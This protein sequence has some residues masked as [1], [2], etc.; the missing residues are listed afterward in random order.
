MSKARDLANAGTALGAVS[1]TELAF[2]DGVTSAIQTQIDAKAPSSTAVTLTGTQ[3]L[4]NKTLTNPV[5]S[6]V[7]NNTL[8][9]TT[10]DMIY[11]SAANTP[12][13]LAIGSTDQVLKV[14]GGI[15]AW[16]TPSSGDKPVLQPSQS[17]FY[18]KPYT[19]SALV[20]YAVVKDRTYY[21][22]IY[23]SGYALDRIG[24]RTA[25]G[26]SGTASTR[27]GIYNVD[28]SGKPSTVFLDAGTVSS[29]AASTNFEITI[30]STPPAGY[31]YLA[32]NMQT[33]GAS[34]E[35]AAMSGALGTFINSAHP[36]TSTLN[37]TTTSPIYTQSGVTGAFATATSLSLTSGNVPLI[38]VR[39]A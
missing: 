30:S 14:T 35:V 22:P 31:Y 28:T 24:F 5:I 38:A 13:R 9:T 19:L 2:V 39:I 7:V 32:L 1:A 20:D 12:A 37:T 18:I 36:L 26:Y 3:T 25:S 10:G 34:P 17:T 6:S 16:A 15:P 11:A 33:V 23:L 4:T 8:T 21:V 27:L 29:T